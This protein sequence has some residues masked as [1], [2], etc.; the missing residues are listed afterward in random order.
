M[1]EG[2]K[3]NGFGRIITIEYDPAIFAKAKERIDAS[4]LGSWIEYRNESSLETRIDGTI[5]LLFSDSLMAIREHEVRRFL[6]QINPHGLVLI[7]D[8]SSHFRVVRESAS[9]LE[10]EGL[11]SVVLLPTPRGL[12]IAQKREGRR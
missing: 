7:H 6:P 10:Q 8:A 5:D 12:A 9:R 1:A 3:A 2:L 4:G 11:L